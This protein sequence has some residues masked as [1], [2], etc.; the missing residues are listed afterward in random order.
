MFCD[1]ENAFTTIAVIL[2]LQ[3]KRNL[4]WTKEQY[5]DHNT[6]SK[7]LSETYGWESQTRK[8]NILRFDD[9]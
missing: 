6:H 9:R 7:I 5:K 2:R 4:Y 3:K 8:E 1:N